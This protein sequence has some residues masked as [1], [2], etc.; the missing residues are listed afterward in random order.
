MEHV[1]LVHSL[2]GMT[3]AQFRHMA[4]G[5]LE[6]SLL[7]E[8]IKPL[9]HALDFLHKGDVTHTGK[10]ISHVQTLPAGIFGFDRYLTFYR[11]NGRECALDDSRQFYFSTSRKSELGISQPSKNT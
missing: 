5:K 1:G 9:L 2:L 11:H 8:I 4:G 7:K 10:V 3:L 6:P